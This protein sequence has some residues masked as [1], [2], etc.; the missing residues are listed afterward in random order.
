MPQGAHLY[1]TPH[2]SPGASHLYGTAG[3]CHNATDSLG[4]QVCA[5]SCQAMRIPRVLVT[6]CQWEAEKKHPRAQKEEGM[7]A[8]E[9]HGCPSVAEPE[10]CGFPGS[11]RQRRSIPAPGTNVMARSFHVLPAYQ[12]SRSP[13]VSTHN[14]PCVIWKGDWK[15]PCPQ[16]GAGRQGLGWGLNAIVSHHKAQPNWTLHL[17]DASQMAELVPAGCMPPSSRAGTWDHGPATP[18]PSPGI[19]TAGS[20]A[21]SEY[22]KVTGQ[23]PFPGLLVN[24]I[25]AGLSPGCSTFYPN[26][27]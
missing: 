8:A 26:A 6:S 15:M 16:A 13:D 11:H 1:P 14:L 9:A 24:P 20:W 3:N 18:R 23:K 2:P 21:Q 10:N 25:G 4:G 12:V 7:Q 19:C 5:Y 22:S 27:C 17:V